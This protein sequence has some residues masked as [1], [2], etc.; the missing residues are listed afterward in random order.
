MFERVFFFS[1]HGKQSVESV[2]FIDI[3]DRTIAGTGSARRHP[4][5]EVL[6]ILQD[7]HAATQEED[8]GC[9]KHQGKHLGSVHI[10][11]VAKI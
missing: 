4:E 3:V 9:S 2:H 6:Q 10:S 11:K 7:G 1:Q 8:Q 5:P